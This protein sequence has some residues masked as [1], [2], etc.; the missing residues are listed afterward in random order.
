[1]ED[2]L[3]VLVPKYW[4]LRV[5]NISLVLK[6]TPHPTT[7][8]GPHIRQP[9]QARPIGISG[10]Y[11]T[12]KESILGTERTEEVT[13][14][15]PDQA[16]IVAVPSIRRLT[17][18]WLCFSLW[19]VLFTQANTDVPTIGVGMEFRTPQ[20]RR[21]KLHVPRTAYAVYCDLKVRNAPIAR[22]ISH[23]W[24]RCLYCL[25]G[26]SASVRSHC[27]PQV[28]R[29]LSPRVPQRCRPPRHPRH[30]DCP[31]RRRAAASG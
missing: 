11:C 7:S 1:M 28:P 18:P 4:P 10:E 19:I 12:E 14:R 27:L 20:S 8:P 29:A 9:A 2:L 31:G 23:D 6:S 17:P 3:R 16:T 30:R 25:R 22:W 13:Q 24:F 21:S 26:R 15:D 5:K